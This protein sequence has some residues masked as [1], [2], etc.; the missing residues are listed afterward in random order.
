MSRF[1]IKERGLWLRAFGRA[2]RHFRQ[3]AGM[4]QEA[5]G[6]K[7]D[8]DQTYISGIERGRRNPTVWVVRRLC[9]ALGVDSTKLFEVTDQERLK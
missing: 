2:V 9:L 5:L 4:T 8:L 1:S 3:E 7:S 6:L